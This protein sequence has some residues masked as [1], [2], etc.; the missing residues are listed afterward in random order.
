MPT[1][2]LKLTGPKGQAFFGSEADE[3]FKGGAGADSLYGEAG[4]DNLHGGGGVDLLDGGEG[5]DTLCGGA[6]ADT[7]TGGQG[8]DT[9][10]IDGRMGGS[11]SELDQ[12]TD[13]THGADRLGMG[14]RVSLSGASFWS[15]D[16]ATYAD[17]YATA[18]QKIASGAADVVAVQIG[19]DVVVFADSHLHD[20]ADSAVV[21]VGR[22]LADVSSWDIF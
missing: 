1:S 10:V 19:A 13:F 12:I 21:L 4:A 15:G 3:T 6:G 20:R 17:A 18:A 16:A 7:L 8:G 11:M 14:D 22:T 5:N 9:F 2:D